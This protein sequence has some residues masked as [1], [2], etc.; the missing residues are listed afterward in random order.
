LLRQLRHQYPAVANILIHLVNLIFGFKS[1]F[2]N[3]FRSR[4]GSGLQVW[5][6]AGLG[7]LNQARLQLCCVVLWCSSWAFC[8]E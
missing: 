4:P 1:G 3:K 2:K 5:T 8:I 7:L 6:R